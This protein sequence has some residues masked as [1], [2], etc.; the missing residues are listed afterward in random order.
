VAG[1]AGLA[2]TIGPDPARLETDARASAEAIRAGW[3]LLGKLAPRSRRD[4]KAKAA[5]EAIVAAASGVCRRF[6]RAHREAIYRTLTDDYAR[7]VRV[8]D[9]VFAAA[10]RWPG[11]VPSRIELAR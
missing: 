8:D 1:V 4:A 6:A 7:H 11:L 5:G 2:Q 10:E 3:N 9:L